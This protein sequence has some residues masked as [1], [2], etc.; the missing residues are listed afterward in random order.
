MTNSNVYRYDKAT[1]LSRIVKPVKA[2]YTAAF[3]AEEIE[4]ILRAVLIIDS[5]RKASKKDKKS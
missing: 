5:D 1:G 4:A 3:T 2:A